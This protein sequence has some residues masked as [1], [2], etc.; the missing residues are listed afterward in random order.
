[1]EKLRAGGAEATL[2]RLQG[3]PHGFAAHPE[4]ERAQ[5]MWKAALAFFE[6]RLRAWTVR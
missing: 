2:L 4:S 3:A 1:M 5:A 6:E